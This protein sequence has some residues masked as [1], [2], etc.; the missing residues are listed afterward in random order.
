[1]GSLRREKR[2]AHHCSK[3]YPTPPSSPLLSSLLFN[4]RACT[5]S[6]CEGEKNKRSRYSYPV[7]YRNTRLH[8]CTSSP[9]SSTLVH[10]MRRQ[11]PVQRV[12]LSSVSEGWHSFLIELTTLYISE[13]LDATRCSVMH[14]LLNL[15]CVVTH[16]F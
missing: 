5:N 3:H 9:S 16:L 14:K 10:T 2:Q 1:M 4:L 12:R 8:P 11:S 15:R 13:H 7:L 6:H